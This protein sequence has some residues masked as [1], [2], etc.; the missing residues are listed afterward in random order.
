ML[1]LTA[2]QTACSRGSVSRRALAVE[3]S[4]QAASAPPAK[5]RAANRLRLGK[6]DLLVSECCLGTMTWGKQNTEAEAHEQLAYA[7]DQ[8][9]LNMLDTA[10]VGLDC[11]SSFLS[12]PTLTVISAT[13]SV[14]D[15]PYNS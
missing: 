12:F 10:E 9:G 15:T 5:L 8:A 7:F 4:S 1:L 14:P 11:C 3:A 13:L 6:S 2:P